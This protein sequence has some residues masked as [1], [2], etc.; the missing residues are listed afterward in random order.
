MWISHGS[1]DNVSLVKLIALGHRL[2]LPQSTDLA[3]E[4]AGSCLKYILSCKEQVINDLLPLVENDDEILVCTVLGKK[5]LDMTVDEMREF[6]RR[7]GFAEQC[8]QMHKQIQEIDMQLRQIGDIDTLTVQKQIL[9]FSGE[10]KSLLGSTFDPEY[11]HFFSR[12]AES[13][14]CGGWW[15]YEICLDKAFNY[16]LWEICHRIR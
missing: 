15:G 13:A 10:Y 16:R 3:V 4:Y 2:N 14:H 5:S 12:M 7:D 9:E 1:E 11:K 6:T 8:I